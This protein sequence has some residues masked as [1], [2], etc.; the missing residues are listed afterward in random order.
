[1]SVF[2][3]LSLILIQ[4]PTRPFPSIHRY[5]TVDETRCTGM[6]QLNSANT[7]PSEW[8]D[9]GHQGNYCHID[10]SNR[11]TCDYQSGLCTCYEGFYGENCG[12]TSRAGV[13]EGPKRIPESFYDYDNDTMG[14][15]I[16]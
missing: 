4:H 14:Q 11:G 16:Y 13:H 8:P 3:S 12:Q 5:T 1:M 9:Y 2:L 15:L 10:C 7:G 6:S